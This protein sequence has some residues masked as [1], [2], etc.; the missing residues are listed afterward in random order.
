MKSKKI[1]VLGGGSGAHAI[2]ADLIESFL[3]GNYK[4][5]AMGK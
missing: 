4:P 3:K 2:A 1:T 5:P